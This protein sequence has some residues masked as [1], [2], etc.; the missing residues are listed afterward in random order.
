MNAPDP[1]AG[2]PADP[3]RLVSI[4]KLV[5]AYYQKPDPAVVEQRVAFGTSGHRGSSL[6]RTFNESHVLA[7]TQ[8]ICDY[9]QEQRI[10][11]PLFVGIDT[12]ALSA[13]AFETALE[14]LAANGIDVMIAGK[15]EKYTPTPA[16]SRA[17]LVHNRGRTTEL[18]DGIVITPC[19]YQKIG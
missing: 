2:R 5:A 4:P 7:V 3:S 16:V 9:R 17:I 19:A 13:P 15:A 12:H 11:G 1:A 14:V 10:S 8:A 18:A 6:A